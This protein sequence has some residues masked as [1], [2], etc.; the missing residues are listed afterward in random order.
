VI[1][2]AVAA[3]VLGKASFEPVKVVVVVKVVV[4]VKRVKLWDL[5]IGKAETE[6]ERF[7][8]LHFSYGKITVTGP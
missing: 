2:L 8:V 5:H 4:E 6:C 1:D 7:T 3:I